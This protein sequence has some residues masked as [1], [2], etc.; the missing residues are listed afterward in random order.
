MSTRIRNRTKQRPKRLRN[1][2]MR[3]IA[4]PGARGVCMRCGCTEQNCRQCVAAQ[5]FACS[6]ANAAQ[7]ICSRC[8]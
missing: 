8:A 5:G 6:W 4:S 3:E 2:R 1:R 7:N